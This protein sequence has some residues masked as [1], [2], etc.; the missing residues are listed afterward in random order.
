MHQGL[1][2]QRFRSILYIATLLAAA[3]ILA[4]VA[5]TRPALAVA[6]IAQ[7]YLTSETI[8]LGS[9]VSLN[10]LSSDQ[11]SPSTI[12]T[13]DQ[14]L[15]VAVNNN[16]PI[17]LTQGNSKQTMVA[18]SGVAPVLVSDYN[19]AIQAGDK[20][21]PSPIAGVGMKATSN[22]KVVGVA[23]DTMA[24]TA[25]QMIKG[26]DGSDQEV[27]LGQVSVLINVG[28]HYQQPEK[29]II[30]A[31]I[32]HVA[33][34]IAGKKASSMAIIISAAIFIIMIIVVMSLIYA[35]IRSSIISVG[36]NPMAQSAVYRNAI[37]LSVLVLAIIGAA[38]IAIY[39]ILA[40][41]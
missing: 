30:P 38:I 19:G 13:A 35:I 3:M 10:D 41:L 14:L 17:T 32:Q 22:T 12:K 4:I 8:A 21:T 2:A 37:Q 36:R 25:K 26:E 7:S 29:T 6:P 40:K 23:Q 27:T 24:H 1:L 34:A 9:L 18:T 31:A 16:A 5:T 20:I 28:Y 33:D 15:G 11:V 39:F